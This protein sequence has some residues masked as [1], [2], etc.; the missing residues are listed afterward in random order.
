M[1]NKPAS[2]SKLAIVKSVIGIIIGAAVAAIGLEAFLVP[3]S[4][5]D[6]GVVGISIIASEVFNMPLGVFLV[7]V[8]IPFIYLGYK[9]LG[10]LFA[11]SSAFGITI[12][13]MLTTVLHHDYIATTD[14]LLAAVF[15][16][17][18][19]GAGVGFVIRYGG[20]M[21]GSEIIAIL[22]DKR[23]PFSVGEIIM[24]INIFILGTAG[25]VFGWDKAMYSFVAY[26]VA[27]KVI[28]MTV[29][30]LDESKSAWI[31]ST[32]HQKLGEVIQNELGRKVTYVE[33]QRA[34]G[35]DADGMIL[36][37][38]SRIEEQKLKD[39]LHRYDPHAFVVISNVHEVMG[40]NYLPKA[41]TSA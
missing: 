32:Q 11:M 25:F 37:V 3:N 38:I 26:F 20:T 13:A 19:V 29:E 12:L 36:T 7:I 9:K 4:L 18:V 6:G 8:N 21:D 15:G 17:V 40:K 1:S 16:G 23:S 30:G 10:K 24:F 34:T 27:Y 35:H 5:T 41:H 31:V 22:A 39:I 14:P 33:G 28:D 2:G